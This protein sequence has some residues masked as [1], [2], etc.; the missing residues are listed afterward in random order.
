MTNQTRVVL[1]RTLF[2]ATKAVPI[3]RLRFRP[4]AYGVVVH[5]GRILLATGI[6][7][8]KYVLPGGGVKL[9]EPVEDALKRELYEETGIQIAVGDL[10][11]AHDDFFYYDPT[12]NAF[13]SFMLYYRCTPLTFTLRASDE[14]E[15]DDVEYP[16]WVPVEELAAGNFQSHGALTMRLLHTVTGS[17]R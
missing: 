13:H 14:V 2:G 6:H 10:L 1:C 8:H 7:T 5:E 9:G 15:D 3:E 17:A 11:H 16:R 12:G 4:S